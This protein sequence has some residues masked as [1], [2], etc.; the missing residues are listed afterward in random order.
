M[1]KA[2]EVYCVSCVWSFTMSFVWTLHILHNFPADSVKSQCNAVKSRHDCIGYSGLITHITGEF[3]S[4]L[5]VHGKFL[6]LPG[7]RGHTW[8]KHISCPGLWSSLNPPQTGIVPLIHIYLYFACSGLI[9]TSCSFQHLVVYL[10]L[11][12]D[13]VQTQKGMWSMQWSGQV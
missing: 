13:Y 2:S 7:W 4:L 3:S 6:S 10:L 11:W 12:V 5:D 9:G 1:W 8:K